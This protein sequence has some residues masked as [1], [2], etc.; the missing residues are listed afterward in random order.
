MSKKGLLISTWSNREWPLI[1]GFGGSPAACLLAWRC[2]CVISHVGAV[3][4]H[5]TDK[6]SRS[7]TWAQE[8][9][10]RSF[11]WASYWT[12]LL[13]DWLIDLVVCDRSEV[14]VDMPGWKRLRR[15]LGDRSMWTWLEKKDM[16]HPPGSSAPTCPL[17]PQSKAVA[18]EANRLAGRQ[19][20]GF[21]KAYRCQQ[22]TKL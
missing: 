5:G 4:W 20:V 18:K 22:A 10:K 12:G 11:F 17:Q 19:A 16:V 2:R 13:D 8:R 6:D 3:R 1:S 9:N 14:F 15:M 7:C 21:V